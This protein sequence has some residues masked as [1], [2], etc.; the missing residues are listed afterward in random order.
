MQ[1]ELSLIGTRLV[2]SRMPKHSAIKLALLGTVAFIAGCSP[3]TKMTDR[4]MVSSAQ[5]VGV[6]SPAPMATQRV[7]VNEGIVQ[8]SNITKNPVPSLN[9]LIELK[10]TLA[11]E[12]DVSDEDILRR[13]AIR[14]TAL[15]FGARGGLSHTSRQ[16]NL[17]LQAR[18][19]KLDRVY[20][21]NNVVI[22]GP[23][24]VLV[25]PP[26]ISKA[27]ESYEAEDSG[28]VVRVADEIY[29]IIEQAKFSPVKPLWH[30]YLI[31]DYSVPKNPPDEILPKTP[32]EKKIWAKYVTEGWKA[33]VEQ[34]N[35][36]FKTD[37][38]LLKRD[39]DGMIRYKSMLAE[40]KVSA[41]IIAK[42]PMG[43][44]GDG[45][46]M[47]VNDRS[48]RITKDPSL[49]LDATQW[50]PTISSGSRSEFSIPNGD[51]E[52]K[53]REFPSNSDRKF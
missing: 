37:M 52:Y 46:A 12:D 16:I 51:Q 18:A 4:P 28:K 39:F 36:I 25:L 38:S 21:F 53:I 3:L 40:G 27:K 7:A 9:E 44:T 19:D 42:A 48:I 29:E 43:V 24:N 2:N 8:L 41:P 26:V 47:R 49:Q 30:S 20:D 1:T 11:E 35:Q 10:P 34:A 22:R 23:D 45:N 33:G 17:M 14:D 31:R 15:A 50:S 5:Q 13:P 6:S 32:S